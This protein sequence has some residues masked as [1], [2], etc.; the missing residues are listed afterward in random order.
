MKR[1]MLLLSVAA[2]GLTL[3]GVSASGASAQGGPF[4]TA[5][6]FLCYSHYQVDP[7]VWPLEKTD[8]RIHDTASVLL[9]MGYWSPYAEKSAPT[10]T[11]LPN[12]YYLT[13]S[14]PAGL[15]SPVMGTLPKQSVSS[16]ELVTQKG[17]LVP[18]SRK[19]VG[20]P[21]LYPLAA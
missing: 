2:A 18:M 6:A 5:V 4:E 21:G 1:V 11:E 9:G 7:G 13:C 15:T 3:A 19:N 12:G 8:Y 17:A 10:Q 20:Q 14:L 16:Q